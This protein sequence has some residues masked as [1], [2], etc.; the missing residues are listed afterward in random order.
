MI[1]FWKFYDKSEFD[2]EE[3]YEIYLEGC[4]DGM[5]SVIKKYDDYTYDKYFYNPEEYYL[6]H[7][8]EFDEIA[9]TW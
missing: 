2:S 3:S 1:N 8:A 4:Y 7:K 5:L 9:K 6:L